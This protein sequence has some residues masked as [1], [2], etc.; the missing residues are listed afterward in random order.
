MRNGLFHLSGRA[1]EASACTVREE[2]ETPHFLMRNGLFPTS[3]RA[4]E[5][6]ACTVREEMETP[7]FDAQWFVPLK[8]QSDG[9]LSAH[10]ARTDGNVTF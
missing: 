9:S 8:W 3:G 6:S 7:L 10:S 4:T 5:A 2:M 1:A